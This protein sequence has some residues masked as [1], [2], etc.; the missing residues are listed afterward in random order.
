MSGDFQPVKRWHFHPSVWGRKSRTELI[1]F[2][3]ADQQNEFSSTKPDRPHEMLEYEAN[4]P[5]PSLL[6]EFGAFL[7]HHKK[8]WLVPIVVV[9]LLFGVLL[10]LSSS[11]VAPFI[12]PLF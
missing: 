3:N 8:W 4:R 7:V 5:Q 12:Y 2:S 6:A 9:L 11:A 1:L 10:M